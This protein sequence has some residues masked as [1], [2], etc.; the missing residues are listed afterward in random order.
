MNVFRCKSFFL[1]IEIPC[2]N[3]SDIACCDDVAQCT[4][5]AQLSSSFRGFQ[6]VWIQWNGNSGMVKWWNGGMV[7]WIFFLILFLL[8]CL[9]YGF[10]F[11][12]PAFICRQSCFVCVCVFCC[13]FQWHY[14]GT[15]QDYDKK[16]V[17]S[18]T[19]ASYCV[20]AIAASK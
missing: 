18:S 12:L 1:F 17:L 3:K 10:V 4:T 13:K 11:S 14:N 5:H 6:G 16:H 19:R 20:L 7:E 8:V 15:N 9:F 2:Q